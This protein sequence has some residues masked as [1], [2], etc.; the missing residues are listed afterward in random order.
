MT[1]QRKPM[2]SLYP[3]SQC[4]GFIK[5]TF[6][7]HVLWIICKLFMFI[8]Y[9]AEPTMQPEYEAVTCNLAQRLAY[10]PHCFILYKIDS[11]Y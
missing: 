8:N 4:A 7:E 10:C 6:R 9:S 5:Y 3:A 2:G 1:K 11:Q